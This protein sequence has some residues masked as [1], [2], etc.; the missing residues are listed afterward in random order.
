VN[1]NELVEVK[2]KYYWYL[3]KNKC[4]AKARAAREYCKKQGWTYKILYEDDLGIDVSG[5]PDYI[6]NY[7]FP[8]E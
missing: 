2:S 8:K 7:N 1:G 4:C 6:K 5:Y 3:D